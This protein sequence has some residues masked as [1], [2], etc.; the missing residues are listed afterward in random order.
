MDILCKYKIYKKIPRHSIAM[1]F[2]T[3]CFSLVF[4]I[5]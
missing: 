4:I 5:D 2:F 1:V 3:V